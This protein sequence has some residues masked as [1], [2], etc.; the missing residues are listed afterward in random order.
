M[1]HTE[2]SPQVLHSFDRYVCV[3]VCVCMCLCG[4][5]RFYKRDDFHA[6]GQTNSLIRSLLHVS[7]CP[8]T[9]ARPLAF[10]RQVAYTTTMTTRG[11]EEDRRKAL[12]SVPEEEEKKKKKKKKTTQH[13][14]DA[15]S[16]VHNR[17]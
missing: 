13:N 8:N 2:S 17:S 9:P 12:S 16:S 11:T 7:T 4:I 14:R 6:R 1:S 5:R 3:C 15:V 10:A